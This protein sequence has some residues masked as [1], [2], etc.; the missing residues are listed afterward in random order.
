VENLSHR[1]RAEMLVRMTAAG[2]VRTMGATGLRKARFLAA[3]ILLALND[4][5]VRSARGGA[6]L[7]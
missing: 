6:E 7:D 4:Y 5:R 2:N 3:K 1:K